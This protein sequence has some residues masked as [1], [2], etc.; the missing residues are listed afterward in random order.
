M[1]V[2]MKK[3]HFIPCPS[4]YKNMV[5]TAV[6]RAKVGLEFRIF[7]NLDSVYAQNKTQFLLPSY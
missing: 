3:E 1:Q 6:A 7:V 5:K 2:I 4:D